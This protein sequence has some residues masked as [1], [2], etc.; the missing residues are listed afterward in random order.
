[1][2]PFLLFMMAEISPFVLLDRKDPIND[3]RE[4]AL[5][6]ISD[7]NFLT[8]GCKN[9]GSGDIF[10]R[11][12]PERYSGYAPDGLFWK[13]NLVY[14]FGGDEPQKTEWGFYDSYIELGF[15]WSPNKAKA[16]F[17]DSLSRN[18]KLILRYEARPNEQK[19]IVIN[20][21][22]NNENLASLINI[23][24]PKK[25]IGYLQEWKSPAL[26]LSQTK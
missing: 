23:C 14:R 20:Y 21:E 26:T 5:A 24:A 4:L 10:V 19:T 17:I 1:M 8:V 22:L 2:S 12:L 18:D 25:V 3:E 9:P 11:F 16:R 7:E 15:L 13:P 6:V